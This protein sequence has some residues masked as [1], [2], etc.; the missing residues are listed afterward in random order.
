MLIVS[1]VLFTDNNDLEIFV[2]SKNAL[3][4]ELIGSTS[5]DIERRMLYIHRVWINKIVFIQCD[6][7]V[8]LQTVILSGAS[9]TINM[10]H[11]E[12]CVICTTFRLKLVKY[13]F[14]RYIFQ[15]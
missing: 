4:D 9:G 10:E 5:I 13:V 12:K 7:F 11:H 3:G 2:W 15:F 6:L 14:Y 1:Y 8:S